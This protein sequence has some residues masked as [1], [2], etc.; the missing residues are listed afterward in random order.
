MKKTAARRKYPVSVLSMGLGTNSV[1][2][3]IELE[4]REQNPDLILFADTGHEWQRTYHFKALFEVWLRERGLELITVTNYG[5]TNKRTGQ[6]M[7]DSLGHWCEINE[8][9][10]SLAFGYKGCS[11]KA[12]RQPM[13]RYVRD[14][15]PAQRCWKAGVKVERLIGIHAGEA[16]RGKIPDDKKFTYRFPLIEWGMDNDDCKKVI[17]AAGLPLPGQSACTFCP[18]MKK[19]EILDL[20]REEPKALQYALEMEARFKGGPH[21]GGS[22]KGLGRRWSWTDFLAQHDSQPMLF[23]ETTAEDCMCFDGRE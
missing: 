15:L 12:K 21:S 1:A 23:P 3:I 8:Q 16:H 19:H 17:E 22:T 5:R 11:V 13:D 14:W 4:K 2:L 6:Y 20:R 9:L 7:G 10:P 18:A